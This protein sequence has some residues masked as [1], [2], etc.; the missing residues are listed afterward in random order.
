MK[1]PIQCMSTLVPILHAS[2]DKEKK[3]THTQILNLIRI[4]HICN[5][6][7]KTMTPYKYQTISLWRYKFFYWQNIN[8]TFPASRDRGAQHNQNG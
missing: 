8:M 5:K 4:S 6:Y 3:D 2:D 1:G 7:I